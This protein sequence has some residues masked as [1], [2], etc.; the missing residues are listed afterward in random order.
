VAVTVDDLEFRNAAGEVVVIN[1]PAGGPAFSFGSGVNATLKADAAGRLTVNG[2]AGAPTV[3]DFAGGNGGS[4]LLRVTVNA[5]SG[6]SAA[7]FGDGQDGLLIKGSSF[8]STG[9]PSSAPL[10]VIAGGAG[11]AASSSV[12]VTDNAFVSNGGPALEINATGSVLRNSFAGAVGA[13]QA[14]LELNGAGV[15]VEDNTFSA[16]GPGARIYDAGFPLR[17]DHPDRGEHLQ[18]RLDSRGRSGRGV[19]HA[20]GSAE[21]RAGQR[22][23]AH[24]RGR[25]HSRRVC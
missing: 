2:G 15:T 9:A 11:V 24:V 4:E 21:R 14:A 25:P 19:Q 20:R 22:H 6:G 10:L 1:G 12:A 17:R 23:G 8:G 3:L 13:G 16:T 5:A 18:R 7:T